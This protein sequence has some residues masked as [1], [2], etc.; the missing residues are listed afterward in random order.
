MKVSVVNVTVDI[1]PLAMIPSHLIPPGQPVGSSR[2]TS[3]TACSFLMTWIQW[4]LPHGMG[5]TRSKLLAH[6]FDFTANK[7]NHDTIQEKITVMCQV[8]NDIDCVI[9][10]ASISEIMITPP[11]RAQ[12]FIAALVAFL[13]YNILEPTCDAL[14]HTKVWA[15][16]N[17][18]F[19]LFPFNPTFPT[20]LFLL[21]GFVTID[22]NRIC[23]VVLHNW[24][25]KNVY[26]EFE[27]LILCSPDISLTSLLMIYLLLLSIPSFA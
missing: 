20:F 1:T 13:I 12:D 3:N 10:Q 11:A 5:L 26:D 17:I 8:I 23:F 22:A 2:H 18:S 4:S 15:T 16:L 6:I 19:E 21:K 7:A 27:A 14:L 9:C 25:M 24:H